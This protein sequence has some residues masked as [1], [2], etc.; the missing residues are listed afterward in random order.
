LKKNDP[1]LMAVRLG[2]PLPSESVLGDVLNAIASHSTIERVDIVMGEYHILPWWSGKETLILELL[3]SALAENTSIMD[4]HVKERTDS[5]IDD[6][7]IEILQHCRQLESLSFKDRYISEEMAAALMK[8]LCIQRL[9]FTDCD[10]SEQVAAIFVEALEGEHSFREIDLFHQQFR[11][12][13]S[14][15][16]H[17]KDNEYTRRW[18]QTIAG[19]IKKLTWSNRFKVDKDTFLHEVLGPASVKEKLDFLFWKRGVSGLSVQSSSDSEKLWYRAMEA[20]N[21]YDYR[22]HLTSEAP[23]MLH[24]LIREIPQ[25]FSQLQ[26]IGDDGAEQRMKK[27]RRVL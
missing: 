7:I 5:I 17:R 18:K 25:F 6:H 1:D 20:A 24:S 27:R 4:I 11:K 8:Q 22:H 19:K 15:W 23:S 2:W 10:I 12:Y 14:R 26:F 21:M 16:G 3:K 13:N 9:F